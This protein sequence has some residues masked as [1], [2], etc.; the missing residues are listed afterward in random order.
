[1][2][3]LRVSFKMFLKDVVRTLFVVID[4]NNTFRGTACF[5]VFVVASFYRGKRKGEKE[6][7]VC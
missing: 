7:F 1:M 3:L 6:V 5:G 2:M 4:D